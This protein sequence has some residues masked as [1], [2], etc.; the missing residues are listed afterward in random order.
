MNAISA[1]SHDLLEF[2]R[3]ISRSGLSC[4][5]APWTSGVALRRRWALMSVAASV[6]SATGAHRFVSRSARPSCCPCL[7]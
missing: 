2:L 5:L 6:R 3:D 7:A 1:I 4:G